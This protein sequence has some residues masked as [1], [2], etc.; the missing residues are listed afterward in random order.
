M[1]YWHPFTEEA[2]DQ[3]K[4]DG[5]KQLVVLPLYPQYSISTSGSSF[6]QLEQMWDEDDPAQ[7][8]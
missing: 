6:R 1:R 4:Q 2:I 3:I 8:N 5:I 7:R